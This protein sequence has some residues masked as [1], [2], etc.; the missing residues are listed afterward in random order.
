MDV[1]HICIDNKPTEKLD[2]G[3]H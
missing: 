2:P 1:P 3:L